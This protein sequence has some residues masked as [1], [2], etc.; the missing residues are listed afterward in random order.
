M[1]VSRKYGS[2]AGAES[3]SSYQKRS[4]RT[5]PWAT[6][7]H[8]RF[9]VVHRRRQRLRPRLKSAGSWGVEKIIVQMS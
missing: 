4:K 1:K 8:G 5:S 9:K 7:V 2:S 6:V 3:A